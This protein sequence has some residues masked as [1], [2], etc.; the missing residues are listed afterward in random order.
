MST[1]HD[2]FWV[3][4]KL[5]KHF[6]RV[7]VDVDVLIGRMGGMKEAIGDEIRGKLHTLSVI[8]SHLGEKAR[9][10]F[11]TNMKQEAQLLHLRDEVSELN[12]NKATLEKE[13][14]GRLIQL[15]ASQVQLQSYM[16]TEDSSELDAVKAKLD[17][18][19]DSSKANTAREARLA[20][21]VQQLKR[22][23][24]L[25]KDWLKEAQD[26]SEGAKLTARYLDKELA[27]RFTLLQWQPS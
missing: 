11:E 6:D 27:G 14:E 26:V 18:Q 16:R 13:L 1:A 10:V 8:F 21:R 20:A 25:L 15:H 5:E 4:D 9:S 19:I 22:E 12:A 2:T 3:L 24:S 17:S 7:W 23:N